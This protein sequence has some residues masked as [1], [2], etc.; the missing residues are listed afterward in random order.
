MGG[1]E[2]YHVPFM[3]NLAGQSWLV[4]LSLWLYA[5][6]LYT[7]RWHEDVRDRITGEERSAVLRIEDAWQRRPAY[8][9]QVDGLDIYTAVLDAGVRTR[10]SSPAG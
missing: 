3:A 1:D 10:P 7:S 9:Q 6:H 4:D 5:L 8:R 2:R